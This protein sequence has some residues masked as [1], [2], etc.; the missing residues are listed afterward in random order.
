M[1]RIVSIYTGVSYA[2][3]DTLNR[4]RQAQTLHRPHSRSLIKSASDRVLLQPGL[5]GGIQSIVKAFSTCGAMY[6]NRD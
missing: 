3:I 6:Y 4:A 1:H 5:D 2:C